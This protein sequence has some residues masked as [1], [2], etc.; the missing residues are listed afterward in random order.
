MT[1]HPTHSN[2]L[3]V[4]TE[5]S[6]RQHNTF[7]IAA[8]ASH[9]AEIRSVADLQS[10]RLNPQLM[11]MPRLILGGGSNLVLSDRIDALVLHMC[12]QG[13]Q[14]VGSDADSVYVQVAAGEN[15]H[16]LVLWTLA[17]GLGGLENMALIPG[18]VGAAP[19]Q[20]IGAYGLELKDVFH[21]LDAFDWESGEL[22]TLDK[23]AC[24][25]AYR[26]SIFKQAFKG[27]M[28]ILQVTLALPRLWQPR[29]GYA[30]VQRFL[31]QAGITAPT[32]QDVC[33][34]VIAIRQSKLPDPAQIGNAGSFF[35]NP[36]V[37]AAQRTQ[38]LTQFPE[39]VS[40]ALED[41]RYKLAAGWLIEKAG[42]KGRQLGRAGVYEKQAL[43]LVNRGQATGA[44]IRALAAAIEHDV[45][46]LFQVSLEA[47]PVFTDS[48]QAM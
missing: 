36:I 13:K 35:K 12:V 3:A 5:F 9:F 33:N 4:S 42:W 25:F 47:E 48:V 30:D 37:S 17:Q 29:L 41:G 39:L 16:Q 45:S 10:V 43:V 21:S 26:D 31:D 6:L 32:A 2:P 20:N 19:V 8:I 40:Y 27:R 11:S 24:Q 44:D 22:L 18:T 7:G 23:A 15:W 46:A 34:A 28:T 38:L 14:I 1:N